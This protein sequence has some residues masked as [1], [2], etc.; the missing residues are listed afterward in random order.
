MIHRF[1]LALILIGAI[2][3]MVFAL[4]AS[5][6]QGDPNVLLVGAGLFILGAWMLL[7]ASRRK[8]SRADRFRM[9]H[10]LSGR[11][12]EGGNDRSEFIDDIN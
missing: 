4:T 12:R 5:I 7:R 9:L 3:L 2:T 8:R 10:R 11:N 6:Q 1:S